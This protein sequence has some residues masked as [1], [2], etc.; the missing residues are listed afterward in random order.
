MRTTN[1]RTET[2]EHIEHKVTCDLCGCDISDAG[3]SHREQRLRVEVYH[4]SGY[5][6]TLNLV[7]DVFD[8]CRSCLGDYAKT[9]T[10][11]G[12][13]ATATMLRNVA[14]LLDD[15]AAKEGKK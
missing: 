14:R 1:R 13:R 12:A 11:Y 15:A 3:Y 9:S 5:S 8:I 2:V 6:E 10:E 7:D 4:D